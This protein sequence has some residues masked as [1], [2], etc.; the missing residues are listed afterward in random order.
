VGVYNL[1]PALATQSLDRRWLLVDRADALGNFDEYDLNNPSAATTSISLPVGVL[2]AAKKTQALKVVEW[3][4]DNRHVL[5]VHTFDNSIEYILFDTQNAAN[6]VN[7]TQTLQLGATSVLSLQNGQYDHYFVHDS[8]TGALSLMTLK[9]S[10]PTPLVKNAIAFKASG[11]NAVLY[12]TAQDAAPGE[13]QIMLQMDGKSYL[14]RNVALSANYLLA[15]A[16]YNGSWYVAVGVASENRVYIYQDPVTVL[17][18]HPDTVLVPVDALKVDAPSY[19]AFSSSKQ[20]VVAENANHF[21]VYDIRYD[22][23]YS[24]TL[25]PTFDAGQQNASWIDGAHLS[26]VSNG[27]LTVFDYDGT[28]AQTLQTADVRFLPFFAPNYKFV[29]SML[30]RP[31]SGKT[32][33]QS[34]LTTTALRTQADQ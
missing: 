27:Y 28:N 25:A 3:A 2:S 30:A 9:S 21:A 19:V 33:A 23:D 15:L 11:N 1:A 17:Q 31:A 16:Q 18:K 8:Q 13:A 5:L 10:L 24:Y 22:K 6:T 32:A 14:I 26:Y 29:Y 12:A 4:S 7:I 34:V 20:Y